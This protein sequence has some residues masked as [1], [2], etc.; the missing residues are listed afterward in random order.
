MGLGGRDTDVAV[1]HPVENQQELRYRAHLTAQLAARNDK[2]IRNTEPAAAF[3]D[4]V[5][6]VADR[7][8]DA[9]G[10]DIT[11]IP[12]EQP[13]LYA[14]F[15][16][17]AWGFNSILKLTRHLD[18]HPVIASRIEL[19]EMPSD[20]SF[21]RRVSTLADE[22]L[23]GPIK[24]ASERAVHAVWRNC[25]H[26]PE[27]VMEHWDLSPIT[28]IN[29]Y[30]VSAETRREAIRN[31]VKVLLSD[32]AETLTFDRAENASYTM[33]EY[34]GV[35][36]H[37]ALQNTGLTALP[38]TAAWL[39]DA[40]RLPTGESLLKHIKSDSLRLDEIETQ[41]AAANASVLQR[42]ETLGLFDNPLDLAFDTV[43]ITWWGYPLE[44][45][46]GKRRSATDATPDWVYGVL[47]AVTKD[48]RVCFGVNLVKSKDLHDSV[49]DD[50]LATAT[51]YAHIRHVFGDKEFYD[52][53]V[54][55]TL[56]KHIGDGWVIKAQR[57]NRVQ[58]F[59]REIPT[60]NRGFRSG[61]NVTSAT[62]APNAFALP[63]R[64]HGQQ[65]L[66][67]FRDSNTETAADDRADTHTV[68]LTDMTDEDVS[69]EMIKSRYDDRWSIETAM[70]QYQHDFHPVCGSKNVK[71]RVYCA[72]IAMLFFNW[73]AL[74]NRVL[75]PQY[76]LPL[77][78]THQELLTAI[79]DV[80]FREADGR[81]N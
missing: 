13:Y 64:L 32:A 80:A 37:S 77:T 23:A 68:Y 11:A 61:L 56:R 20:S 9:V 54:I 45:T 3:D 24:N 12:I 76:N 7:A 52:G 4:A 1:E 31:W 36:A 33:E 44:A 39:Y 74:I 6:A 57:R 71:I 70:R 62:P 43:D 55:E 21:Y 47:I 16:H 73:H 42:G 14:L 18:D 5:L 17:D 63:K 30:P 72:N 29:K 81:E 65:T 8:L 51:T 79:R 25:R 28:S 27:E 10:I 49:L 48:A 15:L 53:S 59:I 67:H 50:L 40:D 75:S 46:I 78:V 69:V 60:D 26:V 38:T 22:G 2:K 35:L 34:I 66:V 58:E 41:F 19:S